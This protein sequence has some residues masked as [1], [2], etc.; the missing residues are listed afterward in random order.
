MAL[1][2]VI[3]LLVTAPIIVVPGMPVNLSVAESRG[4]EDERH[5]SIRLGN[6]GGQGAPQQGEPQPEDQ[7]IGR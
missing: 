5:L 4:A 3:I 7:E 1:V 2:L 6:D